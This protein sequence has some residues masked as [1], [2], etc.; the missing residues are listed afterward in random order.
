MPALAVHGTAG[1][2]H[3]SALLR[4]GFD[5]TFPNRNGGGTRVYTRSLLSALNNAGGLRLSELSAREG[6][7]TAGTLAWLAGGAR[8]AI[9]AARVDL[10]HCPAFVVP[11]RCPV[12]VVVTI[13][14][15]AAILF[16]RDFPLEWR[17]YNLYLLPALAR[18]AAYVVAPSEFARRDVARLYRVHRSR[19]A[20]TYEAPQP[21]YKPQKPSEQGAYR[22][23]LGG[24]GNAPLLLFAGAPVGRK[25]LELVLAALE[26][27]PESSPLARARLLISGARAEDFPGYRGKIALGKLGG[28]VSWLGRVP[29]GE[30]PLLYA[31]V[32]ALV[33]P[34]T[35]EGF[36]LP[37]LE[38]MAVGTP[39]VAS[40]AS[41]LPEV[42][43]EAAL[44]VDPHDERGFAA[45]IEAV[46][47]RPQLRAKLVQAGTAQAARYS[48]EKCAAQTAGVYRRVVS[49]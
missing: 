24:D 33:Y 4:V 41:C 14:D 42:L 29:E 31:A 43:G 10:L 12:P 15:A 3:S 17:F 34:S 48:W 13:H 19:I 7:H 44:L 27:A 5:M 39:V 40:N 35:Y 45:A 20:V 26:N 1:A 32:D 30:M 16:P 6:A 21:Q 18:R 49:G 23:S 25:N 36:G 8:R 22:A 37:P 9:S 46:L 47:T 28:R 11:W 2:A 38:A